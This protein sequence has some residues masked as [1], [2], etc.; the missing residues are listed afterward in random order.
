[1]KFVIDNVIQYG[2]I[3]YATQKMFEYRDQSLAI[4]NKFPAS[5]ARAALEEL[6]RYTTDR[7]Y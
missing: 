2:G 5:P 1:M 3:E 7:A 6:V 4:L